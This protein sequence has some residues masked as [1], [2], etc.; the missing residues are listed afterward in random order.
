MWNNCKSR[1]NQLTYD[2]KKMDT[3]DYRKLCQN[4]GLKNRIFYTGAKMQHNSIRGLVKFK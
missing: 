4:F 3:I 2:G 1:K